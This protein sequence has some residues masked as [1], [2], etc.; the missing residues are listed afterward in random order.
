MW[1]I[2]SLHYAIRESLEPTVHTMWVFIKGLGLG[3]SISYTHIHIV[4]EWAFS[5]AFI[6]S[7][8]TY[9]KLLSLTTS[10][11]ILALNLDSRIA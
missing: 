6:L 4:L 11:N 5:A 3:S 1:Q 8:I 10:P 9:D 7:L 2:L